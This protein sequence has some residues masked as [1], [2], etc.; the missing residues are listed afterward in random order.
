MHGSSA[1]DLVLDLEAPH[2]SAQPELLSLLLSDVE[3]VR[4]GGGL[5]RPG[6]G[7]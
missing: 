6:I 1:Q 5:L 4:L 3:A 7:D 2:L